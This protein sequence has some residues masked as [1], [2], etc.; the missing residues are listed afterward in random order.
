MEALI[1]FL[2]KLTPASVLW[3]LPTIGCGALGYLHVVWRREEREDR[4]SLLEALG[5]MT[6]ALNGVKL[7]IAAKTG[8]VT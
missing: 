2:T 4:K 3:V 8:I 6:E 1:E 5:K 7:V